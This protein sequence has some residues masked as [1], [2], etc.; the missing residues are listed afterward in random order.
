ARYIRRAG[1][2]HGCRRPGRLRTREKAA[3]PGNASSRCPGC[4]GIVVRYRLRPAERMPAERMGALMERLSLG[5]FGTSR[6]ENERRL[7]IHPLHLDRIDAGLRA[8][9]FES[10][11]PTWHSA[12][13]L[14]PPHGGPRIGRGARALAAGAGGKK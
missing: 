6:E 10:T 4:G 5:V 11:G 13:I 8:R 1:P 2:G 14:G 12:V 3:R 9:I 7:P